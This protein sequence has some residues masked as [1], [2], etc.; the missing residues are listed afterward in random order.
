M[1]SDDYKPKPDKTTAGSKSQDTPPSPPGKEDS[2]FISILKKT[3]FTV[4][5]AVMVIGG[6]LAFI[7]ALFLV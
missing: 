5:L 3:G 7:V 6:A 4:W 1:R 2:K